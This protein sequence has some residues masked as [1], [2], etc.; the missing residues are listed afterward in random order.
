[1]RISA[2]DPNGDNPDWLIFCPGCKNAHG[3][4]T[5]KKNRSGAR[6]SFDG[7]M[8]L[9]TIKPSIHVNKD[10]KVKG[11][12]RCHCIITRGRIQFLKDSTHDLRGQT[13]DLP[14][15]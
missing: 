7:D 15:I 13:V 4:W 6:W 14:D 2:C 10:G 1:M 9:P 3:V 12:A 8:E 11:Q 5:S